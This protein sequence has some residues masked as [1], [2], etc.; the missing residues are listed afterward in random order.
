MK[1]LIYYCFI[2][3]IVFSIY[4][5]QSREEKTLATIRGEMNKTLDDI[6]SYEPIETKIDSLKHD[7]YGDTL[8]VNVILRMKLTEGLIVDFEKKYKE[9]K[10]YL[11]SGMIHACIITVALHTARGKKLMTICK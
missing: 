2:A 5:C 11:T 3:I 6:K 7:R 10:N 4:G 9:A 1:K 8:L